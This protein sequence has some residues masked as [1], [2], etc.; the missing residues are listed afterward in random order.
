M[1]SVAAERFVAACPSAVRTAVAAL[2]AA[3]WGDA[4]RVVV[5]GPLQRVDAVGS[6]PGAGTDGCVADVWLSWHLTALER[7][8]HVRLVLDECEAGP[9]PSPELAALL[10]DV[11][12][13]ALAVGA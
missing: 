6:V 9:D 11:A 8:T 10:D 2:V 1:Q 5:D 7:V 13:R 4:A 3:T 12:A